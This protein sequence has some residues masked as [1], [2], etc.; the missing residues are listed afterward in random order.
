MRQDTLVSLKEAV[1]RVEHDGAMFQ[2]RAE[3]VLAQGPKD[4]ADLPAAW[5][6]QNAAG[7]ARSAPR[8]KDALGPLG[9]S[10]AVEPTGARDACGKAGHLTSATEAPE[11]AGVQALRAG[12]VDDVPK[13]VA[14]EELAH[15]PHPARH[16][17]PDD[18]TD[19]PGVRRAEYRLT[20]ES[21]PASIPRVLSWLLNTT[22]APLSA[23][24]RLHLRGAL[25]E[26]LLNAVEHGNL[27]MFDQKKQ[28]ALEQD[29]YD[30]LLGQR[31][32][33]SR[34]KARQVTIHVR[35]ETGPTRLIYRIADEGNGF[36]WR[37]FLAQSPDAGPTTELSGR[38][39]FLARSFFPSLTY[40]DRG[41]EV[42]I[43]V[44][45]S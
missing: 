33:Q 40:N 8:V 29:G 10:A 21:D 26:L 34:L 20:M 27:E 15:A 45:L 43:T 6:A 3:V 32:T 24:Q 5:A 1:A 7:L 28:Q 12:A 38:G 23:T 17:G 39:I 44:P 42:T 22:A 41:N 16:Q 14:D 31:L 19:R 36:Q 30:T 9:A 4:V 13:P 2:P 25:H 37:R 11:P 18:L 35:Y